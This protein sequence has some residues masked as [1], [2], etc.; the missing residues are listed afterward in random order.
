MPTDIADDIQASIDAARLRRG[1]QQRAEKQSSTSNWGSGAYSCARC[2]T[3]G[4][5]YGDPGETGQ[6]AYGWNLTGGATNS[7]FVNE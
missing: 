5:S 3:Q 4:W 7:H 2:H 6:G 1:D